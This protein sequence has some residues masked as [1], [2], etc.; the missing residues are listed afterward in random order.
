M[1]QQEKEKEGKLQAQ[2]QQANITDH[3]FVDRQVRSDLGM[4]ARKRSDSVTLESRQSSLTTNNDD[5]QSLASE[6][7]SHASRRSRSQKSTFHFI[8]EQ[9]EL[10]DGFDGVPAPGLPSMVH[11]EQM[12]QSREVIRIDQENW[13][14]GTDTK[15]R[16]YKWLRD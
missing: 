11:L 4:Q 2:G 12:A 15:S 7:L 10:P 9:E 5:V 1:R 14:D 6:Q 8:V 13:E 16:A 3:F